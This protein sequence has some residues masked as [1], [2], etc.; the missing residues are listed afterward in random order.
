MPTIEL[1]TIDTPVNSHK[2]GRV[3]KVKA[4]AEYGPEAP[5]R[6][7]GHVVRNMPKQLRKI[8]EAREREL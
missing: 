5:V 8:K 6:R 3:V 1:S 4:P 2:V 7:G